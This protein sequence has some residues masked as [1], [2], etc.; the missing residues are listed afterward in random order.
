MKRGREADFLYLLLLF[1]ILCQDAAGVFKKYKS[2]EIFTFKL[3]TFWGRVQ[4]KAQKD[5][6]CFVGIANRL[7]FFEPKKHISNIA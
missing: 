5:N 1:Q 4:Q 7:E 2:F 3:C 6:A